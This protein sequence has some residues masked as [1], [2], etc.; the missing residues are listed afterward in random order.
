L[1]E[2]PKIETHRLCAKNERTTECAFCLELFLKTKL[3]TYGWRR[4]TMTYES[5]ASSCRIKSYLGVT[6]ARLGCLWS[7]RIQR[8]KWERCAARVS[9]SRRRSQN[10]RC[11]LL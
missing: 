7:Q 3:P 10:A 4:S 6:S 9:S 5:S 2:R 8:S 1:E 11:P